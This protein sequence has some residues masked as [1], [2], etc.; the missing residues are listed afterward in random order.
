MK[1]GTDKSSHMI[2]K[3]DLTETGA[4]MQNRS[5]VPAAS[6]GGSCVQNATDMQAE[7]DQPHFVPSFMA[8]PQMLIAQGISVSS[9]H[10][11]GIV[12]LYP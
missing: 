6:S 1:D 7:N 12:S 9:F 8:V 2:A 4:S 11:V 5:T 3:A 10:C